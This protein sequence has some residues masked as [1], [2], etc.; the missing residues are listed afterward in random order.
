MPM[1][2]VGR[3]K[4]SGNE[5]FHWLAEESTLVVAAELLDSPVDGQDRAR[6]VAYEQ[7]IGD[8]VEQTEVD[9]ILQIGQPR[10]CCHCM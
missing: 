3:S 8:G 2:L 9:E 4:R 10:S 7:A 5:H 1:G 6:L